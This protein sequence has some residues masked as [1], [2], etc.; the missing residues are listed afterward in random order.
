VSHFLLMCLYAALV[1][2]FF[3]VL[4][5]REPQEQVKLFAQLFFGMVIGGLVIAWLML[6]FPD[7]P[8]TSP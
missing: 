8:P 5:R 4:W 1:S 2:V 3:A 7:G 6:P